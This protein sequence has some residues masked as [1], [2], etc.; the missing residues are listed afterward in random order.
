MSVEIIEYDE[1]FLE[2]VVN[3]FQ[4]SLGESRESSLSC[5]QTHTQGEDPKLWLAVEDKNV[6]GLLAFNFEKWNQI[7]RVDMIGVSPDA[8]GKGVGKQMMN[9]A[10]VYAKEKG[11]RKIYVDTDASNISAQI[12]YIKCG[13]FPEYS[14]KDYYEPGLDGI[15]FSLYV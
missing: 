5:I 2:D 9:Q 10:A 1:K 15:T 11:L 14:M 7:G 12:F 4:N 13:Y 3:I 6:L 8:K